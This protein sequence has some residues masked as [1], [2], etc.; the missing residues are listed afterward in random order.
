VG[1]ETPDVSSLAL[2]K[3]FQNTRQPLV[4]SINRIT[5][6]GIRVMAG[7]IIGFD[8]E[9]AGAGRRIVQFVEE[10]GIST[11]AVA[12]LQALP[13]TGLWKR[14]EREG[15]LLDAI[16]DITPGALLNFPPTRP[17]EEIIAECAE[18]VW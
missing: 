3:K 11:A 12:L 7:F 4:D 13:D 18:T 1:I 8:G 10:T 6:A 9:K 14:L 5:Q 16:G 17:A 2:T 15:R